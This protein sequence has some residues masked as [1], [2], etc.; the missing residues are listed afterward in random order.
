ME[1]RENMEQNSTT[2][3]SATERRNRKR[4][5]S[6][7]GG[8]II[9]IAGILLLAKN[10]GADLPEWLFTWQ[11]LLIAIGIFSGFKHNFRDGGWLFMIGVGGI[12]LAKDYVEGFS[13][14][15]AWPVLII[16]MGLFMILRSQRK[17]TCN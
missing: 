7:A 1:A 3:A 17:N 10:V 4:I 5:N 9:V 6:I 8:T 12:F 13:A 2:E 15:I 11:M 16:F 14:Y